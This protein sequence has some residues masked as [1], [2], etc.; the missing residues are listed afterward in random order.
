MHWEYLNA[1]R[2]GASATVAG[3]PLPTAQAAASRATTAV[4]MMASSI[5]A[6]AGRVRVLPW[7]P[8][9]PGCGVRGFW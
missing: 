7:Y 1:C 3:E 4:A 8:E 2:P 5:R 6:A 9:T